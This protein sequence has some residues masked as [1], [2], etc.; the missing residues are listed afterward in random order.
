MLR[1]NSKNIWNDRDSNSKPTA[2]EHSTGIIFAH[3]QIFWSNFGN[4]RKQNYCF[5]TS[6]QSILTN[7][8]ST[9]DFYTLCRGVSRFCDETFSSHSAEKVCRGTRLCF[10]IFRVSENSKHK[11]GKSQMS[12]ENM[13]SHST[14]K[15]HKGILL[16]LKKFWF[17]KNYGWK[18]VSRFFRRTFLVSECRKNSW[19]SLQYFRKFG[20][21]KKFMHNRGYHVF[22]SKNFG[23]TVQKKFVGTPSTFHKNWGMENFMHQRGRGY[24]V[25]PSKTFVTLPKIF[26]GEQFGVSENFVYRKSL[27]I[28]RG[29]H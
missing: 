7:I 27:C 24:H 3:L 25:S 16:F 1:I 19:P 11:R 4:G 5:D 28:A 14:E 23:V 20:V 6:F 8:N 2:W 17:R 18:V 10:R 26:V 12:V 9:T 13:L 22:P 15:L 21:S 29:Y